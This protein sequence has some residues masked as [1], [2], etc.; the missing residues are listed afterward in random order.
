M[1]SF[2]LKVNYASS[3]KCNG[4]QKITLNCGLMFCLLFFVNSKAESQ[5]FVSKK[6]ACEFF[7][8]NILRT[9]LGYFRLCSLPY[10]ESSFINVF[11]YVT[12]M[13]GTLGLEGVQL[14]TIF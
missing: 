9:T 13:L 5:F 3:H 1:F 8:T 10:F 7:T 6:L 4:L 12:L 14:L 11:L 2:F